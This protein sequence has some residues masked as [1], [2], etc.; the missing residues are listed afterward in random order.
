MTE[1]M[2]QKILRHEGG[3]VNHKFDRGAL[4]NMGVTLAT[5]QRFQPDATSTDIENLTQDQARDVYLELWSESQ[6]DR[7]PNLD[8]DCKEILFDCYLNGGPR[9]MGFIIQAAINHA[10]HGP[11]DFENWID[12]DGYVGAGTRAALE[13][14]DL[15]KITKIDLQV[16]RAIYYCNNVL[17]GCKFGWKQSD[18]D[19]P[20]T[21]QNAFIKGWLI[22]AFDLQ[23]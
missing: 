12:I 6:I 10:L 14:L 9:N 1:S 15:G 2:F 5:L 17:K 20:R 8:D 4:T 11:T 21:N 13:Q 16:Q 22:R 3:L 18:D 7:L 23:A 19:E